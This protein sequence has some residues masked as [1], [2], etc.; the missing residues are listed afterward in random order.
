[1]MSEDLPRGRRR[2]RSVLCLRFGFDDAYELRTRAEAA[3]QPAYM[4]FGTIHA[5]RHL[6]T[7]AAIR[8]NKHPLACDRKVFVW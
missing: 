6:R 1:M 8:E 5:K 2:Q 3:R 7:L 4:G